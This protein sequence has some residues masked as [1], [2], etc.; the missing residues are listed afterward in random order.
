MDDKLKTKQILVKRP[1]FEVTPKGYMNHGAYTAEIPETSDPTTPRDVLYR[2]IKTQEDFLREYYPSGH[3]IWDTNTYPNIWKRDPDTNKWYEQPISRTAFAFQQVICTKHVLHLTGNDVQFEIADGSNAK[4]DE[5]YQNLLTIFK[6]GWLLKNMEIRHYEAVLS[7]ES[8]GDAAA[9]GFFDKKGKLGVKTLS[10]RNG[11]TLYP[12]FNSLSGELEVFAR[13]FYDYDETGTARVEW[14][15]VWDDKYM[16]R[17]R[18]DI[19]PDMGIL[20]KA[21]QKIKDIFDVDGHTLVEKK[22]HGFPWI[23]V[24][25]TRRNDGP[26]WSMVQKNIEDYEEAF[27]YLCE[28]NKAYAF[29]ILTLTGDGDDVVVVGDSKGAAKMI[30]MA[31]K[32]NKAEFLNGTDASNAFAT[33]LDKA[34]NLIY[35]LSFTVKPPELKSGD[36][37]GVAI[38]LLYSPALEAAMNEAQEMQ[39]FLDKLVEIVKFGVGMEEDMMASMTALP[40]NAWVEPYT[41]QNDTELVTNLATAVQNKFLSKQTASER[42]TKFS[43]NDEFERIVRERKEEQEQDLLVEIAGQEAQVENNIE[44][45]EALAKIN[46]QQSGNDVN[47]GRGS[48]GKAGRPNKSGIDWDENGNWP[49]RNNWNSVLKK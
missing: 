11:D 35:E 42:N 21:V 31:D 17:Y 20:G 6:K 45:E 28:N 19:D 14:V 48:K 26:C 37:P 8:T 4:T 18:D 32:D 22:E 38:K 1:F 2:V 23:P 33:Q 10:F 7:R 44:E 25:Y 34:Y 3:R 5:A 47:T 15:E 40:I 16:Y 49:G 9:V 12:H 41:H 39:P 13:K 46:H 27:S 30:T 29:P 24:A 36:L 43:K